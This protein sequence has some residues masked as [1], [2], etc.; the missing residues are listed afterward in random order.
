MQRVDPRLALDIG[1]EVG[2]Q[3]ILVAMAEQRLDDRAEAVGLVGR[4]EAAADLVDRL[5]QRRIAAITLMRVVAGGAELLDLAGAEAEDED[6][7]GADAVA[8]L[9]V[10][11]VLGARAARRRG[12]SSV[13]LARA[14]AALRP[15]RRRKPTR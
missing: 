6:V 12:W 13:P 4:E 14:R 10:G 11:A 7:V 3:Q 15:V 5:A 8:D 2:E 1:G 9:D